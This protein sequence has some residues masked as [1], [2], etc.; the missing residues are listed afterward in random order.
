MG[1]ELERRELAKSGIFISALMFLFGFGTYAATADLVAEPSAGQRFW[2]VAGFV[3]GV[4]ALPI[5]V[6]S[7]LQFRK[8]ID[9]LVWPVWL[10]VPLLLLLVIGAA[11][12]WFP[13]GGGTVFVVI[14][15]GLIIAIY[16]R[17]RN[18]Q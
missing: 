18:S 5:L 2:A 17:F 3:V 8:S 10:Q 14:A 4:A 11:M 15:F 7:V 9:P 6:L 12:P 16:L 1:T 13:A